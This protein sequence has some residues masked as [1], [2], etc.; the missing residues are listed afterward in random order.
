VPALRERQKGMQN[1]SPSTFCNN[2]M[3]LT[4]RP[5]RI[6][7]RR[8]DHPGASLAGNVRELKNAVQRA[9]ILADDVVELDFADWPVPSRWGTA[10]SSAWEVRWQNSSGK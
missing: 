5:R 1:S 10:S 3:P 6:P 7:G 2:S 8:F 9:Y 4:V